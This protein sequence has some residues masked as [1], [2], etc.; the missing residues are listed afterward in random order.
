MKLFFASTLIFLNL[1]VSA[2]TD[3]LFV[4]TSDS[5]KIFVERSGKGFPVLFIH[6]G[7]G[8][9]SGYFQHTGGSVFE[10][11]V[12]MIYMD[13]RG[14][15]RSDNAANK[16]YSLDRII[17]DFEEVREALG[18]KQ[19]VIMPHSFGGILATRYAMRHPSVIKAMV[20]LNATI[21]V[22][23]SARWGVGTAIDFLKPD[24]FEELSDE[25]RP[26]LD[27]W[28]M[29]FRKLQE[30]DILYKLMFDK[31]DS[32]IR[33]EIITQQY[34]KHYEFAGQVWNYPEYFNDYSSFTKD[35][36]IPVL[37]ITGTRDYTIGLDHYRLMKFPKMTHKRIAGGHALYMENNYELY[38]HVRGFLME[39]VQ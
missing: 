31:K 9:N 32:F 38:R 17:K 5:V 21:N 8:S 11:N 13:Q 29:A 28:K 10:E 20:Y 26:L 24:R 37:V 19:W 23:H 39:H 22:Q 27:R 16:N 34:A 36:D 35:I 4:T 30:K 18:I 25:T 15:G 6:G 2:Q 3:S 12:Q 33:H 1:F 7:P 14:S